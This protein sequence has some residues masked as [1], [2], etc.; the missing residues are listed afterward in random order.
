MSGHDRYKKNNFDDDVSKF[1]NL[2]TK[3]C[4]KG[5]EKSIFSSNINAIHT[6]LK[7]FWGLHLSGHTDTL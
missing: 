2:D 7:I 1:L 4:G 3:L 6:R 5:I